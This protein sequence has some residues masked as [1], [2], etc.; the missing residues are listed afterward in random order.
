MAAEQELQN[1]TYGEGLEDSDDDDD[2]TKMDRGSRATL[3]VADFDCAR[4]M[5]C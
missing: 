3:K 4:V 5:L 1:L 2:Y